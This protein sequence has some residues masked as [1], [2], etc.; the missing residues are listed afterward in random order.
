MSINIIDNIFIFFL[1]SGIKFP[2]KGGVK[3]VEIIV[4]NVNAQNNP[5]NEY[6]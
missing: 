2:A 5:S 6:Y 3:R 1:F 4:A